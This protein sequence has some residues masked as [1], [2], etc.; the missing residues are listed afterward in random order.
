MPYLCGTFRTSLI[1]KLLYYPIDTVQD[2][3]IGLCIDRG[4]MQMVE[5]QMIYSPERKKTMIT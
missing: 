1:S 4:S 2:M 3:M 5:H